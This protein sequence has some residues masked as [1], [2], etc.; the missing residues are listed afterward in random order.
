MGKN[1][2]PTFRFQNLGPVKD[3][4]LELGDLTIITGRNNTGKTYIA[5]TL[6]GFLRQ[7]PF[8]GFLLIG[9]E[10]RGSNDR[11]FD[12]S[13]KSGT[14]K[15]S[16]NP[17]ELRRHRAE[18]VDQLCSYYSDILLPGEFSAEAE[19]FENAVFSI[20]MG[21][22]PDLAALETKRYED[23]FVSLKHE[24]GALVMSVTNIDTTSRIREYSLASLYVSLLFP[25][26][27][28]DPFILTSER[29][30][31]ALFHRELDF[32]RSE[33][34]RKLQHMESNGGKGRNPYAL[35][36]EE[37]SRFARTVQ[38]NIGHTRSIPVILERR[39]DLYKSKRYDD[40]KRMMQGYYKVVN[41]GVRFV[42]RARKEGRRFDIPLH[43]A[44]TSA[45]GLSDM[46]FYLRHLAKTDHLLI[47]DEPE[48]HLD[49]A[50][51]VEM[52]R[53]LAR[54]ARSG[55]KV[56]ITTH[57]DY[58]VKEINNLIMLSRSFKNKE[59]VVKE[60]KY[61]EEDYL[62]GGQVRAYVAEKNGLTRCEMN[63]YGIEYPVFDETINDINH[64]ARKL[65][66]HIWEDQ[67]E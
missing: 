59:A 48:T 66:V 32:A 30:G 11:L 58:I 8:D 22:P 35:I 4:E 21:D 50:N 52:A 38:D 36:E 56:L 62:E 18:I 12:K 25:E 37:S 42:S 63:E 49:T 61:G 15:L 39:S 54:L 13:L 5:Y 45:R 10:L 26:F 53:M 44:S 46:Y 27:P 33:L 51:Q 7:W 24:D 16:T 67:D 40:I 60:L 43:Q 1:A 2:R 34:V 65:S 47:I 55:V 23:P 9:R 17:D 20:D 57:S 41:G 28:L 14:L 31:I 3:A 29:F 6:Y 19:T 64:R